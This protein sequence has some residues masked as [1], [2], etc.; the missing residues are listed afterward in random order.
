VIGAPQTRIEGLTSQPIVLTNYYSQTMA[1]YHLGGGAGFLLD[2]RVEPGISP[3]ILAEL[4]ALDIRR[5]HFHFLGSQVGR[6]TLILMNPSGT[7]RRF[8]AQ[9]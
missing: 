8:G 2:P 6:T 1:I 5:V 4:Q 7:F 3:A 9:N